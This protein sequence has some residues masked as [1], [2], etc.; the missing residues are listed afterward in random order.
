MTV[1]I[2]ATHPTQLLGLVG[3]ASLSVHGAGSAH[4]Q[5]GVTAIDP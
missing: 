1:T 4:P 2:T 5:R 3:I